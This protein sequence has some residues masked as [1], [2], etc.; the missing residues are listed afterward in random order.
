MRHASSTPPVLSRPARAAALAAILLAALLPGTPREARAAQ[1]SPQNGQVCIG[2]VNQTGQT[3]RIASKT[4]SLTF[5]EAAPRT[6]DSFCCPTHEKLCF[7]KA[8][9]TTKV[10]AVR[11][12]PAS[13]DEWSGET[14]RK[15]YLKPGAAVSVRLDLDGRHII[16]EPA[17]PADFARPFEH[18]DLDKDG[19]VSAA[20]AGSARIPP[21]AFTAMDANGDGVL[22]TT[23]YKRAFDRVNVLKGVPF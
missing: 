19:G 6:I 23:E 15:L 21:A 2:I 17:T 11:L 14:C 1:P 10:K 9:G 8:D 3:V 7:D 16:C 5:L 22:D 18:L 4:G 13:P 12:D 20:E